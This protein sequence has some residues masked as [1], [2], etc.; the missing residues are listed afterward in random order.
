MHNHVDLTCRFIYNAKKEICFNFGKHKGQFVKTVLKNE[1][2]YF[3][4]MMKGDFPKDTKKVLK[5]VK[6]EMDRES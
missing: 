5:R 6:S 4:W 2:G 3:G 1:P